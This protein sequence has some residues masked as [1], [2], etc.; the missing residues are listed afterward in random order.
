MFNRLACEAA[1]NSRQ[2]GIGRIL[3]ELREQGISI[4]LVEQN[5]EMAL[6]VADRAYVMSK[7]RI[8]F[9]GTPAELQSDEETLHRYLGV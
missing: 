1:S 5:L 7:G 6:G 8:V 3:K 4:L 2:S 9:E